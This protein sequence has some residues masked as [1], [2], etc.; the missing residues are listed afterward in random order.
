MSRIILTGATT[1]HINP[2]GNNSTGDGSIGNPFESAGGCYNRLQASYDLGGQIVTM[3]HAD[4]VYTKTSQFVG[5]L[6]GQR[7]ADSLLLKGNYTNP[8]N[9]VIKPSTGYAFSVDKGAQATIGGFHMDMLDADGGVGQDTTAVGPLSLMIWDDKLVFGRNINPY[10]HCSVNGTLLINGGPTG[11]P[12]GYKIA[13]GLQYRT[14]SSNGP[15]TWLTVSDLTGIRKY[16]GVNGPY[17]HAMCHVVAVDVPNSRVQLSHATSNSGVIVNQ[18]VNFSYGAQCHIL[19]G[20]GSRVQYVTNAEP[21]RGAVTI[22]HLPYFY[23][24]F[25]TSYQLSIINYPANIT[26]TGGAAGKRF[27]VDRNSVIDVEGPGLGLTQAQAEAA[28]P[29]TAPGTK[30]NG[31]VYV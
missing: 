27:D 10:N 26:F 11:S 22:N 17:Q 3:Q 23:H 28:L 1:F 16:M 6:V 7:G 29:G 19:A 25:L 5:P 30:A 2:A 24:A 20:V 18:G 8:D 14:W 13:P 12:K 9:C 15:T 31:G 4:G 21:N